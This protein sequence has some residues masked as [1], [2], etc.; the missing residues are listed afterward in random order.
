[1]RI[2]LFRP[3]P[4]LL[5]LHAAVIVIT[6]VLL[7]RQKTQP[8]WDNETIVVIPID[9]A[10]SLTKGAMGRGQS[11]ESI[12]EVLKDVK[13]EKDVKAVVLRI[14][15]PGG[16]VGAVQEIYR[17][18][19]EVRKNGKFVVSSF[20]DVAASGG[21]YVACAGDKIVSNPGA[22]TGSIGVIMQMPNVQGLLKKV[23]VSM[24]TI[25]SGG[26]KD[27][28]SPFRDMTPAERA[29]FSSVIMDAYDQFFDAV[30]A[31]RSLTDAELKPLADGRIFSGRMAQKAKL[32][33]E[34]GG[35]DT[36]IEL[37]KKQTGL[38][39]K[40][41]KIVRKSEKKSLIR[42]LDLLSRSPVQDLAELTHSGTALLYLMQ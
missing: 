22:I 32:V 38:E 10:I 24:E 5:A 16:S 13:D 35:L 7:F 9:G 6:L 41:P 29:H 14:N 23:G 17:A 40:K 39:S 4:L 11:V 28:G 27:S 20:G 36:A 42:L 1:M 34:L 2:K 19:Q 33:D 18:V 12:L 25:K 3:F 26:M 37:A 8:T 31:G 15:S 30:K 21:Y